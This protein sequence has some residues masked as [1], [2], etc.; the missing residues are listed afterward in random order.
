MLPASL[1]CPVRP[2]PPPPPC[3]FLSER[4][5]YCQTGPS[6]CTQKWG[7][8]PHPSYW[9]ENCHLS[10][11]VASDHTLLKREDPGWGLV[12]L[13]SWWVIQGSLLPTVK[14][15]TEHLGILGVIN[16]WLCLIRLDV[17]SPL[18]HPPPPPPPHKLQDKQLKA[19][20][21]EE[22][23]VMVPVF[24]FYFIPTNCSFEKKLISFKF[25]SFLFE[26]NLFIFR[27]L[28]WEMS[29]KRFSFVNKLYWFSSVTLKHKV[30]Y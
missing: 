15:S 2:P 1:I 25:A 5:N 22:S 27:D 4:G 24:L 26:E 13:H 12:Q 21:F 14:K 29:Q 20:S 19:C 9:W 8:T 17:F 28:C 18:C 23:G 16:I 30:K 11:I 7:N 6:S 10:F 3:S